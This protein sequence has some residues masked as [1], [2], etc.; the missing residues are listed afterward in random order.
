MRT[1]VLVVLRPMTVWWPQI[2]DRSTP[3]EFPRKV[4]L[5]DA[6][7]EH[8][9]CG[10][11]FVAHIKGHKSHSIIANALTMLQH[12]DHRGACGCEPNTGD[13]AGIL[14]GIPH[15]FLVKVAQRDA[16]IKL[17]RQGHYGAGLIFL[18]SDSEQRVVSERALE[19]IIAQQGLTFLGWRT[20]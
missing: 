4:G 16:N 11:G 19:E 6:Q 9:S 5:Y 18:P 15:D 7:Y 3:A 2:L 17:P 1:D 8:D 10:V 20:V 14:T 13:G 12:M